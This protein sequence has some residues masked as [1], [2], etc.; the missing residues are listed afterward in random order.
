MQSQ[1]K[2]SNKLSLTTAHIKCKQREN[3]RGSCDWLCSRLDY[4]GIDAT[5]LTVTPNASMTRNKPRSIVKQGYWDCK[6]IVQ[7]LFDFV[8]YHSCC[9]LN[10]RQVLSTSYNSSTLF[11]TA[12][13]W[14]Q[15]SC[16]DNSRGLMP[17]RARGILIFEHI[18]YLI[19]QSINGIC[20]VPLTKLDSGAGQK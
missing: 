2:L 17:R 10:G 20:K 7:L 14:R 5:A 11:P 8:S 18:F 9:Q 12:V 13:V 6:K 16:V 15:S 19:N 1:E 3:I 4:V